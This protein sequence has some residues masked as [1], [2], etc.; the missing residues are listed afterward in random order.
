MISYSES[1]ITFYFI[2]WCKYWFCFTSKYWYSQSCTTHGFDCYQFLGMKSIFTLQGMR[3]ERVLQ[4]E[5]LILL[6]H[7]KVDLVPK[8]TTTFA[9]HQELGSLDLQQHLHQLH[10]VLQDGLPFKPGATRYD[11]N[12]FIVLINS[13]MK[14]N[15]SLTV[16]L[17]WKILYAN[18]SKRKKTPFRTLGAH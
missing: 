4:W 10:P 14:Y 12:I 17:V 8:L 5:Q 7:G 3:E 1:H 16:K 15:Q 18:T 6:E 11:T 13:S 2:F 9:N